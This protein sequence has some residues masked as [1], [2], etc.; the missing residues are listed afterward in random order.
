MEEN[1]FLECRAMG[2]KGPTKAASRWECAGRGLPP[3]AMEDWGIIPGEFLAFFQSGSFSQHFSS[4]SHTKSTKSAYIITKQNNIVRHKRDIA[5]Q[6]RKYGG[7]A[8]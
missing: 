6:N 2:T 4:Q 3:P 8:E 5:T 7:K 1:H